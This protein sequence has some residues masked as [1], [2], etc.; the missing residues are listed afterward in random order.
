MYFTSNNQEYR[1]R[2]AWPLKT[3][4]TNPVINPVT[5]EQ[6]TRKETSPGDVVVC[7]LEYKS[8]NPPN[9][10]NEL[11]HAQVKRFVSDPFDKDVAR[12]RA[13]EKVL[14]ANGI[15]RPFRTLAWRAYHER[16]INQQSTPQ[17]TIPGVVYTTGRILG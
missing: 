16:N 12:K 4:K 6:S 1:I 14:N 11:G 17:S 15:S 13:L 10:W 9:T 7:Y 5:Q 3:S 8:T 2:F